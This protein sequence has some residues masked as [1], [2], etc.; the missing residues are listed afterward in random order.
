M[1]RCVFQLRNIEFFAD[2][3]AERGNQR[4]E[5]LVRQHL[6]HAAFFQRSAA[7]RAAEESPENAGR[8]PASRCRLRES[9]STMNSSFCSAFLPVQL[10]SLPTSGAASQCVLCAR[11]LPRL[12]RRFADFRRLNRLFYNPLRK[13]LM[14]RDHPDN[15][16]SFSRHTA[17]NTGLTS[18]LPSLPFVCPSNCGF[19]TPA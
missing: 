12:A 3:G 16:D 14:L 2:A 7:F 19:F 11:N 9:P 17:S 10:E 13:F 4:A 5:F 1:T 18:V 8:A 15:T 6:I